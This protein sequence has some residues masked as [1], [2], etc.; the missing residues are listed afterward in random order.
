MGL[1]FLILYEHTVREYESDLLLKLELERRGYTAEIRQL[2]DRKKLKYFTWKKPKVLVSSCMYDNEAI[3]SHVYNNIGRCDRIVNL[4]WEQM[5]SDTQEAGDWFNMNGNAKKCVQTCWG[6]RTAQRLIDHGMEEKNTPVTG[7]VMMDFLRPE[8][9][10]YF[11]SKEQLGAEHC[12]DP[13]KKLHLYTSSFGYASMTDA[14]VKE[15]SEMAGTDFSGF[16]ATNRVSMAE[17]LDWF[18]RYLAGHPEVELIYRRH[19][20]EWNSP[21]LADLAKKRPNFHVIF[22]DSV[23]QWIV[24]ADSISIW[25]STAIAEVYMA[26]KSCHILR[27]API[28]HEYDP[29]I[30]AGA[31]YVTNYEDFAAAMAEDAPPFPIERQV[32]EGY[33][34]PSPVPAYKRMADLLEQVRNEPPRDAPMGEGFTPHFN[35]LKFFALWG[36]HILFALRLEPKKVFFFHKG[37]AGFAQRIYGYVEKAY[38]PKADAKAMEARIA[39]FVK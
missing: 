29:V 6:R 24:A 8:F 25:M 17:T 21:A 37:L 15:L 13:A 16:A 9:A 18:D 7:A 1:D 28:E 33:F 36:V 12:L 38:V 2:L 26:G 27:P 14:E 30:Y 23:K 39:P 10:G 31:K 11:K 5:L 3:N 32:I 35:W 19:P 22:S 20:S 4:H 34:D